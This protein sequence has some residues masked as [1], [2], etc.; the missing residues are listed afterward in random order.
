MPKLLDK[1]QRILAHWRN[2]HRAVPSGWQL[3]KLAL[4]DFRKNYGLLIG[5]VLVVL[6][7]SAF[8]STY[9][10]AVGT[11]SS[12][13]AYLTFA[14]S[15]M[16]AALVFAIVKLG[17]GEKVGVKKAYYEGSGLLVRLLLLTIIFFLM[18]LPLLIGFLILAAGL[19]DPEGI[20][21]VFE[22]SM[23]AILALIF[24]LPSLVML[25]RAVFS[26]Y[27]IAETAK[28]PWEAVKASR[29][30]VRGRA[31]AV[32]GRLVI[33]ALL[34]LLIIALPVLVVIFI[35]SSL[36]AIWPSFILQ[37]VIGLFALPF[38]NLYLY[39]LYRDLV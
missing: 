10:V 18:L 13:S 16:N 8:L 20:L 31:L 35:G 29:S 4:E 27:I 33:L 9:V 36:Q 3:S 26:F 23:L 39:R 30:V 38:T 22:K 12:L 1:V 21:S 34:V 7:P 32:F 25:S 15:V 24:A 5:I 11:D 19:F 6:L 37:I 28:G 14:N 17:S 2:S